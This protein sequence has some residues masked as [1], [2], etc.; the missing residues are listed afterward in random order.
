MVFPKLIHDILSTKFSFYDKKSFSEKNVILEV[1]NVSA[2]Y[3]GKELVL[4][5]INLKVRRG[6]TVALVG[7]S[8]SG[9]STLA[10]VITGR[11]PPLRGRILYRNKELPPELKSRDRESLRQMQ[12]I[13]QMP[14]TAL[15][16]RQ[17]IR[18]I[19]GRPLSFYFGMRGKE[20]EKSL[21]EV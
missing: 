4:E 11:L 7:E 17:K 9:K 6:R 12:M 5:D 15:N 13:Y 18:K 1:E 19:I 8:G 3:T 16:P 21:E 2:S 14:D 10:R 20:R